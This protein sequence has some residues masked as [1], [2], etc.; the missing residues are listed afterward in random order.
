M[1]K[2]SVLQDDLTECYVCRTT[3]NIHIH[4]VFFGTANRKNSEKYHFVVALCQEHHTG[5]TGAHFNKDL[6]M[7][8][9]K[10]AQ[11]HFEANLGTRTD[12]RGIFGK[13]YL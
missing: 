10:F 4:H 11:E 8:L 3:Q 1:K 7:H 2:Y 12:F 13:S 5:R 9:K 6:D